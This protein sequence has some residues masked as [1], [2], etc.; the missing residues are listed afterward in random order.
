MRSII[1]QLPFMCLGD[2]FEI[3]FGRP[4]KGTWLLLQQIKRYWNF[5]SIP[6][7]FSQSKCFAYE[8][9]EKLTLLK[10][11]HFSFNRCQEDDDQPSPLVQKILDILYATEVIPSHEQ[12]TDWSS[13]LKTKN[14]FFL[15]T[16]RMVLL[17]LMKFHLKMK[18]IKANVPNQNKNSTQQN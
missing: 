5:V 3:E 17:H 6:K 18:N 7:Q 10:W 1:C 16:S 8:L 11:F 4:W 2:R 12:L 14:F 15:F 9:N 13:L